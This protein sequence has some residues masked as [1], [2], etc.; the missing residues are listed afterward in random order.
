MHEM[1]IVMQIVEICVSSIP[2]EMKDV[3]VKRVNLR[4][5]RLAAIVPQSLKFCFEIASKDT[6]LEGAELNIEEIPVKAQCRKCKH[7][8]TIEGPSFKCPKCENGDI[9]LLSGRELDIASLEMAD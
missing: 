6:P 3:K 1:G 4:I 7:Q 2:K 5:G 8:W 9:D